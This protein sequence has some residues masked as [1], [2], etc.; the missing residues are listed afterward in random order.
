MF[1]EIFTFT[2]VFQKL[3]DSTET[4]DRPCSMATQAELGRK[5][6]RME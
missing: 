4:K 5:K 6:T 3:I 2:F 1:E